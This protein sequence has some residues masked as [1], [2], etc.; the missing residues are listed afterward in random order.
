MAAVAPD[1][2]GIVGGIGIA[3]HP[4]AGIEIGIEEGHKAVGVGQILLGQLVEVMQDPIGGMAAQHLGPQHP[5]QQ[6]HQQTGRHPLAHHIAHH[7]GPAA[8]LPGATE[9]IGPGGDEVVVVAAHLEGRPAARRELHPLNHRA[10]IRQQLGLNFSADAELAIKTFVA[11]H[12]LQQGVVFQG[13]TG[14]IGHQLQMAAVHL[15]PVQVGA[16]AKHVEAPPLLAARHHRGADQTAIAQHPPHQMVEVGH[17]SRIAIGHGQLPIGHRRQLAQHLTAAL[18]WDG[19]EHLPPEAAILVKHHQQGALS[20]HQ[21]TGHQGHQLK[22]AAQVGETAQGKTQRHQQ[23]LVAALLLAEAVEQL[24]QGGRSRQHG[25]SGPSASG[26]PK[27][28]HGGPTFHRQRPWTIRPRAVPPQ[29][30]NC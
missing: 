20:L 5:P 10:S 29:T 21:P 3:Q 8:S 9:Q 27:D 25:R 19:L 28:S 16:G 7:Q 1:Q 24:A 11:L 6:G 23:F 30:R 22:K 18:R 4:R 2:G 17:H 14:E 12:R 26:D 15:T 13:D